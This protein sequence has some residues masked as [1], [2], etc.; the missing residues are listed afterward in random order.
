MVVP[1]P[2]AVAYYFLALSVVPL[3]GSVVTEPAAMTLAALML[4]DVI[5]SRQASN[6]LKYLTL[7]VLFVNVSIGGTLTNFAAPP[8]LMVAAKW[9]WDTGTVF[10]MFGWKALVAVLDK[11]IGPDASLQEGAHEKGQGRRTRKGAAGTGCFRPG[12]SCDPGRSRGDQSPSGDVH[13]PVSAVSRA[14]RSVQT[15]SRRPDAARGAHGG[16]LSGRS[17]GARRAAAMV[18]AGS[19]VE[20]E[21]NDAVSTERRPSRRSPT[22]PL[23][24]IW[25]RWSSGVSDEFK[26]AL[27]AG[28]V[29]GGG[30]HRHR[31]CAQSGGLCDPEEFIR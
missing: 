24:P 12:Q 17:R 30:T 8:I 29:T 25:D 13:R 21:R 20:P 9:G 15:A 28:A 6:R 10:S 27:V 4:R 7:G 16:L 1:L 31:Q 22:T 18:A 26:Y 2:A 14:G 19:L 23:L 5:F 3:F 11:R